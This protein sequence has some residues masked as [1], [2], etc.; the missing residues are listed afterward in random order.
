MTT[1]DRSGRSPPGSRSAS[2]PT[3][4]T[5]PSA[6]P[7]W[8]WPAVL[9]SAL[10]FA[11]GLMLARGEILRGEALRSVELSEQLLLFSA[12]VAAWPASRS[13]RT[14]QAIMASRMPGLSPMARLAGLQ[15]ALRHEPHNTLLL[16]WL[17]LT[18]LT[19]GDTP[20]ARHALGR[21][22]AV[23]PADW[24]H[25]RHLRNQIERSER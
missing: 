12:S 17:G 23:A 6:P 9:V 19:L 11:H 22:E 16:Y 14:M 20:G 3:R 18:R 21:L 1:A 15:A 2:A 24:G 4:S 10:V 13:A 7:A 5:P 25:V 8:R